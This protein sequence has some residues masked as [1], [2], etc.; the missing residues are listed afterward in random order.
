VIAERLA[1]LTRLQKICGELTTA[2]AISDALRAVQPDYRSS[3][4]FLQPNS[5]YVVGVAG[6]F[7]WADGDELDD[8]TGLAAWIGHID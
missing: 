3:T 1:A 6:I 4:I 2:R 8:S 5:L 7:G